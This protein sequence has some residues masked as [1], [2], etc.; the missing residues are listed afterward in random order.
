ME[1]HRMKEQNRHSSVLD[2]KKHIGGLPS[3]AKSA[4]EQ[5]ATDNHAARSCHSVLDGPACIHGVPDE[6]ERH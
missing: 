4:V 5:A 6:H 1:Q 2:G 3:G